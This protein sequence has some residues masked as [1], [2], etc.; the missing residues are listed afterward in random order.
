VVIKPKAILIMAACGFMFA[1]ACYVRAACY[2]LA[3][4]GVIF[5]CAP[6]LLGASFWQPEKFFYGLLPMCASIKTLAFTFRLWTRA[7]SRRQNAWLIG[8]V[9][10]IFAVVLDLTL[11]L[12]YRGRQDDK[13]KVVWKRELGAFSWGSGEVKLPAGFTYEAYRGID[14]L[15]GSLH[16]ARRKTGDYA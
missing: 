12:K 7:H 2:L 8:C 13:L 3:F 6:G 14:T 4:G 5:C 1:A 11:F 10:A 15:M 9:V 16:I